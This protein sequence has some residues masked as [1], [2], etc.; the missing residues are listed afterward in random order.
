MK[1]GLFKILKV[2]GSLIYRLKLPINMRIHLVFHISLLKL[3]SKNARLI[4]V[5]LNDETQDNIYE[6]EKI[7]NDQQINDQIYYL[8]K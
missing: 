6:I 8:I 4:K 7:L 1:L 2:L 5:Q 3:A